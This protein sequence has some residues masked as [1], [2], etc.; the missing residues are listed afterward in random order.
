MPPRSPADEKKAEKEQEA[1][2]KAF[3]AVCEKEEWAVAA[4]KRIEV[5]KG[6]LLRADRMEVFRLSPERLGK[7]KK[8]AKGSFHG[9][10]VLSRA[11]LKKA[12]Q[13]KEVAA[14]VGAAFHWN[15]LRMA[16]CFSPRHG[17]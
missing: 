13:R 17:V 2:L 7:G 5:F 16:A 3:D 14:F 15:A 9:Y 10:E 1:L 8:A 11:Q 12:D 4:K 6:A